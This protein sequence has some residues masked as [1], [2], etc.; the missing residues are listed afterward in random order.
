MA[1]PFSGNIVPY[2]R[3]MEPNEEIKDYRSLGEEQLKAELKEIE[4]RVLEIV[5]DPTD[6]KNHG[7]FLY[8]CGDIR[9]VEAVAE[10]MSDRCC[11]LNRLFE[12]HCTDKEIARLE[13][14]NELLL[15][16]TNRTYKRTAAL[17]RTLIAMPKDELD[18]DYEIEGKLLPEF[19]FQYSMLRLEDDEYYGSDF[20]R[21]APILLETKK[22]L[23]DW[24]FAYPNW[25]P[26]NEYKPEMTDK[27][28][29]CE[30][31]YDDGTTWAEGPLCNAELK[32]IIFCFAI[33][34]LCTH[35]HFSIP[36][37]L[38]INDFKM[39][40]TLKVQQFSD[41]ERNRYR[42][43]DR[44]DLPHF[45][46][47]LLKEAASRPEGQSLETALLQRCRDYFEDRADET[48]SEVGI[49]DIDLYLAKLKDR[50]DNPGLYY[51]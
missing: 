23:L 42:W 45:K 27:E 4:A 11:I 8:W 40:I 2:L 50:I 41:Q 31:P 19:D 17:F 22:D 38:R 35:V 15:D 10:M 49:S 47:V 51:V 21:M 37:V 1:L 16:M 29:E 26:E 5:G 32:H 34:N 18:D 24:P 46:E 33:H 14:V 39:E 20:M 30:N 6:Y 43:W 7:P 9:A 3:G 36:D 12:I 13:K 25:Y 44:Y 48:L 28:L